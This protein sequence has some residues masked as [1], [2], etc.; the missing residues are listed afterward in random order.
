MRTNTRLAVCM[1][2][3]FAGAGAQAQDFPNRPVSIIAPFPP[4]GSSDTALRALAERLRVELGQPIIIE[5]KPGAGTA[6]GSD[7]VARAAPDGYTLLFAGSSFVI[8]P[9][10]AKV[11][12]RPVEDFAPVSQVLNLA[13]FLTVRADVPANSVGELVSYLRAAPGKVDYS[14]VGAGS[15][16]HLQMAQ[17]AALTQ[18][19]PVHIPYKG[20]APALTDLLGGRV[21]MAFD[22][23]PSVGQ[24]VRNGSLRA[25]AVALPARSA[26][27]PDV[28]TLR[29]A[30]VPDHD[31]VAWSALLAPAGTPA[32]VIARLNAATAAA[33]RDPDTQARFR[34]FG[35]EPAASTP[36]ELGERIA[37]ETRKF[38]EMSARLGI[39]PP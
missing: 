31:V 20:S 1:A 23:Y 24:Y 16:T 37:R 13:T 26:V 32:P 33:L 5:N 17:F 15:I 2:L 3:V 25:L 34:A 28:P 11:N 12:Y 22:G 38:A 30:G 9:S 18:T 19:N 7:F 29:E 35:G 6:I 21:Q 39:P 4:G 36:A 27:L 14:S 10:I 8:L